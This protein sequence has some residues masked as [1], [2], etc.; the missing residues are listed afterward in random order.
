MREFSIEELY[1]LFI[2]DRTTLIYAFKDIILLF[3]CCAFL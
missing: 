2:V 1:F 3:V